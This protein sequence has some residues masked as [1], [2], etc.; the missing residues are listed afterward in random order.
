[1]GIIVERSEG[2]V[3]NRIKTMKWLAIIIISITSGIVPSGVAQET[4]IISFTPPATLS[5]T[6]SQTNAFYLIEYKWDWGYDWT[7]AWDPALNLVATSQ[8]CTTQID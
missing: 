4:R 6:N 5:W 3:T 1:M 2:S 8:V 7:A